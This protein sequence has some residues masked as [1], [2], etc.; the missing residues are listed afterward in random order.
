MSKIGFSNDKHILGDI[1]DDSS[2]SFTYKMPMY[3]LEFT[4][5]CCLG[6][7]KINSRKTAMVEVK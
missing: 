2:Q 6:H 5:T 1:T 4:C 3:M 7:D